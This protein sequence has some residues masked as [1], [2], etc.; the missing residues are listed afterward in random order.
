MISFSGERCDCDDC[1]DGDNR[2]DIRLFAELHHIGSEG[3]KIKAAQTIV[4]RKEPNYMSKSSFEEF[5]A[6]LQVTC[7]VK[8]RKITRTEIWDKA[9][10]QVCVESRREV[11]QTFLIWFIGEEFGGKCP[12]TGRP[13]KTIDDLLTKDSHHPAEQFNY[14]DGAVEH[15]TKKHFRISELCCARH[16]AIST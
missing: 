8:H 13:I 1:V 5:E 3:R 9:R 6:Y 12:F 2:Y 15:E 16:Y 4:T 11:V 10:R 14:W 7:P